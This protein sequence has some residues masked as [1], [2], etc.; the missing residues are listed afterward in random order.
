MRQFEINSDSLMVTPSNTVATPPEGSVYVGGTLLPGLLG[1]MAAPF[2]YCRF[3]YRDGRACDFEYLYV[4]PAFEQGIGIPNVMG[5]RASTVYPDTPLLETSVVQAYLRVVQTG[6]PESHDYYSA[7]IRKWITVHIVRTQPEHFVAI[8]TGMSERVR[9]ER[10]R[11]TFD[12]MAEGFYVRK[13]DGDVVDH[14]AA[15]EKILGIP[16]EKLREPGRARL[17]ITYRMDGSVL[18]RER[19]PSFRTLATGEPL[20]DEVIGWEHPEGTLKWLSFNTQPIGGVPGRPDYVIATFVDISKRVRAE[21]QRLATLESIGDGYVALDADW[22]F[23]YVNASAERMLDVSRESLIGR[24]HW[25]CYP[26]TLGTTVEIHYRETAAGRPT[27]FEYEN[28]RSQRFVSMRCFPRESGGIEVFFTEETEARRAREALRQSN[29][30][31]RRLVGQMNTVEAEERLRIAREIHD[32]LQQSLAAVRLELG[33]ILKL[34]GTAGRVG[35]LARDAAR[36]LGAVIESTRRIVR[37]LR[38]PELDA[39]G[40]NAALEE[41]LERTRALTGLRA[42]M[43][44]LCA[45]GSLTAIPPEIAYCLYRIAQ[46]ALNN[47]HKHAHAQSVEV[48]LDCSSEDGVR[49]TVRDDGRGFSPGDLQRNDSFGVLGMRERVTALG[50]SLSIEPVASGGTLVVATIPLGR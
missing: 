47:V 25:E 42:R 49:M 24:V 37:D 20:R 46:E 15:A 17:G 11:S 22:C 1:Q 26:W 30:D 6:T 12:A 10:L 23:R 9:G 41:M 29:E 48:S 21:Q 43:L 34:E 38:P 3:L 8:F 14:N 50:G 32:D 16:A 36:H 27:A 40:L 45:P 4:N 5:R 33:S 19:G 7:T 35:K 39:I 28:V 31:L 13:R 18:A 2:T 44:P